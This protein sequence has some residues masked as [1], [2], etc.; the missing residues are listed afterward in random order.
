M[1]LRLL[2]VRIRIIDSAN[3]IACPLSGFPKMFDLRDAR[4]GNY[5]YLFNTRKNWTY[6]GPMPPLELFLPYG[7]QGVPYCE[8]EE[9][10]FFSD[11]DIKFDD[12]KKMQHKRVE[13]IR[14]WKEK[15]STIRE[16][17]RSPFPVLVFSRW[18]KNTCGTT[19]ANWMRIVKTMSICWYKDVRCFVRFS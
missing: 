3:F 14:W 1:E 17:F 18:L 5:P 12:E 16:A 4:K 13:T 6:E 9:K 2:G 19:F 11:E 7:G 15:V 8:G 10:E